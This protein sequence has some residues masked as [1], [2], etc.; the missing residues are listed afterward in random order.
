M[1]KVVRTAIVFLLC[2]IAMMPVT[3][4][5]AGSDDYVVDTYGVL[6][7]EEHEKLENKARELSDK[8]G[9]GVYAHIA[10][11]DASY[12]DIWGY[13]EE[14]YEDH[15]LGYGNSKDG[16]L[17]IITQSEYG[18]SYNIYIPA[19]SNQ[20]YFTIEALDDIE[21][22]AEEKLF[23]HDYYGAIK[24]Y[25]SETE[26]KLSFYFD[27]GYPWRKT[28]DGAV[29][30]KE[31]GSAIYQDELLIGYSAP[32]VLA[33]II[34][35]FRAMKHKTRHTATDAK[36]YISEFGGLQLTRRTDMFL[37]RTES[38]TLI[39][40]DNDSSSGGGGGG[41]SS[42]GGMHSGGGHF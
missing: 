17:F 18:G 1:R 34:V 29:F 6:S 35:V 30:I 32:F 12:F 11:D 4:I 2:I 23:D 21:D 26:E 15:D 38:R 9:F 22:Y 16:I 24:R 13:A 10:Y 39:V 8:Y 3:V 33:L 5:H 20:D 14:Y 7:E 36:E 25:L 27:K 40:D 28:L 19:S 42:S 37:N 41:Y 31:D